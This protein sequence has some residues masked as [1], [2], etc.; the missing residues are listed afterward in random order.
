MAVNYG[1]GGF[2]QGSCFAYAFNNNDEVVVVSK[3]GVVK[4]LIGLDF[5]NLGQDAGVFS[6]NYHLVD[7]ADGFIK[8]KTS[9]V[10]LISYN[11]TSTLPANQTIITAIKVKSTTLE[12]GVQYGYNRSGVFQEIGS[13]ALIYL[14]KNDEFSIGVGN[15][16]TTE[17]ITINVANVSIVKLSKSGRIDNSLV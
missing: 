4:P 13:M 8:V 6:S 16:D 7:I 1:L 11:L 9:G 15:T 17:S 5:L 3:R 10:F 2:E 12:Y 14:N